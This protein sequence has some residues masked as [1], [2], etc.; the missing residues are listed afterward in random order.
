MYA[1]VVA[2]TYRSGAGAEVRR[3]ERELLLPV[4]RRQAGFRRRMVLPTGADAFLTFAL[5]DSRA[6]AEAAFAAL[7]PLIRAHLGPLIRRCSATPARSRS[8]PAPHGTRTEQGFV[9]KEVVSCRWKRT[10]PSSVAGSREGMGEETW[11]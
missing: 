2:W 4:A 8:T 10:R 7:T 3:V 11:T 9:E 1:I 6:E 5:Y